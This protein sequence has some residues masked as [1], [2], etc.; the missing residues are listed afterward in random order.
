MNDVAAGT[1]PRRRDLRGYGGAPPHPRWPGDARVAV[2]LVINFEE[3]AELSV[4]DGDERNESV[5]EV[6]EL[7]VG[8]PDRCLESHF[9]YG[10]RAGWWRIAA[11][12]DAHEVP[13]TVSAC[14]RAVQRAPWIAADAAARG[15]E[16]ACHGWRW[17]SHAALDP[18]TE[19][20]IIRDT[21]AAIRSAAGVTPVGWHTRSAPS[22]QTR[23][24]LL[25]EGHFL[26]DSDD[27]SDDLPFFVELSGRRHLVVPYA[28]DT[29][30]MHF[31]QGFQRF[32]RGSDFADYVL[33]AFDWLWREGATAPK[34]L[35][36]GL[37]LRMIGRPGRI[38]AL[39][40]LLAKMRARGGVWFARR[41][42]IARHWIA[43]F[44]NGDVNSTTS[45]HLGGE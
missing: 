34:M 29:N 26:Y 4:A 41:A 21:V 12:L 42:D 18:D 27:Y 25:E 39:D 9:D 11:T 28:F 19:R 17:E 15:H 36:I 40:M 16:I 43:R 45:I 5:H 10:T 1:L 20:K 37:H 13:V 8:R 14:G 31:H 23:R 22:P 30:D 3:G 32:A 24:L 44:G 38:G 35:S 2:S 6:Q 7:V 33:D